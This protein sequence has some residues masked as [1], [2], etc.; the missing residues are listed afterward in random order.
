MSDGGWAIKAPPGWGWRYQ[1]N[2]GIAL[3]L[4]QVTMEHAEAAE[5]AERIAEFLAAHEIWLPTS[6]EGRARVLADIG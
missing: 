3:R 2:D 1:G 4:W 5:R 6:A